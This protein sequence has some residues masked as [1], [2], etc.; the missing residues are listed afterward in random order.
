[1]R[2]TR[3][4]GQS[5]GTRKLTLPPLLTL[6]LTGLSVGAAQA[7]AT[8]ETVDVVGQGT[9]GPVIAVDGAMLWRSST[10]LNVS[11]RMPTPEPG[12]YQYPPASMFQPDAVP[13]HPEA[14]SLWVFVFNFPEDCEADPCDLADFQSGR[15]MGGAFNAAGHLAGGPNLQFSGHVDINS[16]PFGGSVLLEPLTAEVHLAVAPHGGLQ[17]GVMPDQITTPIGNPNDHWWLAFFLVE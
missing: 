7:E 17:P 13:G 15:G 12:T 9:S 4:S 6:L 2:T 16:T 10:G 3:G 11:L 1:M 8:K 14:F 5:T